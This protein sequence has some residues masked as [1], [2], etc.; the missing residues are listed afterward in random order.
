MTPALGEGAVDASVTTDGHSYVVALNS[1][2]STMA[3]TV[4]SLT[5]A[6][7]PVHGGTI[8]TVSGVGFSERAA[9]QNWLT[10]AFDHASVTPAT[11]LN[12]TTVLC[13][14]PLVSSAAKVSLEISNN[15]QDFSI[16]RAQFEYLEPFVIDAAEPLAGPVHGGTR[17]VVRGSGFI[18]GM[19]MECDFDRVRV[20]ATVLSSAMLLCITPQ[21]SEAVLPLGVALL[22]TN[23]SISRVA[24][25]FQ[26]LPIVSSIHPAN[27]PLAGGTR[28]QLNGTGFRNTIGLSCVF[29]STQVSARFVSSEAV[30]CTAPSHSIG[31]VSIRAAN[32]EHT[33]RPA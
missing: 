8:V 13:S 12:L 30:N 2:E 15:L 17:V 3:T 24:F 6:A 10:C 31:A 21:H 1:F 23:I 26:P 7:G 25:T 14:T 19:S 32:D 4:S 27:G 16:S 18:S 28:V 11:Y 22:D 9:K 29:G 20:A 33:V 5:P